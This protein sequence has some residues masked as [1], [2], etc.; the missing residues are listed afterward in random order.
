MDEV[1]TARRGKTP[2]ISG[3]ICELA[4]AGA[5]AVV[6]HH[7]PDYSLQI[8]DA[9]Q[10]RRRTFNAAFGRLAVLIVALEGD[11]SISFVSA[12]STEGLPDSVM[13]NRGWRSQSKV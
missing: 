5:S 1:Y 12:R 3:L 10:M 8:S 6:A 13:E 4:G 11:K 2:H 9:R 7:A